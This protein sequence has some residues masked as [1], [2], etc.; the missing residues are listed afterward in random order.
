MCLYLCRRNAFST[1]SFFWNLSQNFLKCLTC[2]HWNSIP[3]SIRHRNLV[4]MCLYLYRSNAFST[5]SF[6]WNLSPTFLKCLTCRHW[7]SIPKSIGH[8]NIVRMCLHLCRPNAF[9]TISLSE[10]YRRSLWIFSHAATEIA[11]RKALG[12]EIWFKCA[13]ICI[14]QTLFHYFICLKFIAEF[15]EFSHMPPLK[16]NTK[17]T[18]HRNLVR[19][20]S[21]CTAD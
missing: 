20:T 11:Y 15:Y 1:I 6:L 14:A 3:K 9:S 16:Q 5:I 12:T 17:S 19:M 8:R 13:C 18:G 21:C 10:I 2:R 7:N 4:R